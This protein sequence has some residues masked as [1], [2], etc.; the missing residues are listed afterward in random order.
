MRNIARINNYYNRIAAWEDWRKLAAQ[1]AAAGHTD[2]VAQYQP[3]EDA[4]WRV[5]D[6]QIGKLRTALAQQPLIE[7]EA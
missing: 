7:E 4:G 2:L 3:A 1:A 5:I 6:K